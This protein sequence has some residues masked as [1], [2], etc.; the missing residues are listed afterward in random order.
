MIQSSLPLIFTAIVVTSSPCSA[1][2]DIA[3]ESS[4]GT[5]FASTTWAGNVSATD[6][7]NSGQPTLSLA[8]VTTPFFGPNGTNDGLAG[9]NNSAQNTFFSSG[10]D[11]ASNFTE[12]DETAWATYDL[13]VSS[14][15][16]GYDITSIESFMG[17]QA[18]SELHANQI[19]SIEIST[20]ESESYTALT[21]V[22]FTPF[23]TSVNGSNHESH[24][25][26][27]EDAT[28]VLATGVDSIRFKF[29][30][31]GGGAGSADG[32]VVREIDV[33]GA[34]TLEGAD[35][36]SLVV[37]GFGI[38]EPG[39]FDMS[40][41]NLNLLKSYV[42]RRSQTLMPGSWTDVGTPFTPTTSSRLVSDPAPLT[43]AVF[44]RIEESS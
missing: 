38:S 24:V 22:L 8:T 41:D 14:N 6:L 42:L 40:A 39:A 17:W 29:E 4:T 15:P 2:V 37:L 34:P 32:T 5:A 20:V 23:P 31:P 10:N 9:P 25:T 30:N 3:T 33:H 1:A 18:N 13:D 21:S 27:T 44:Y 12:A 11:F 26:I 36:P 19:Y 35:L 43:D 16:L 28:G 7:I